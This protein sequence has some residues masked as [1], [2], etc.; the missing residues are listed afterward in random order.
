MRLNL[1]YYQQ[2]FDINR[3][4]MLLLTIGG[5]YFLGIFLSNTFVNIYLWRQSGDYVTIAVYNLAVYL[6]QP[7]AFIL[8]GK[9]A[10]KVDRVIV[11]RLGVIFLSLFFLTVLIIGDQASKYNFLLGSVLGIGYGFYWLA[12]NV[13]TFEITEPETR[14]IFNGFLGVLQ[15][16]GGMIGPLMAGIIIAKMTE[17]MGYTTIFAISFGL[18][19]LAVIS[20]FFINRRQAEGSF[21]FRRILNERNHNRNWRR[22]LSAHVTQGLREGI[23]VFVISIWVY[24]VTGSEFS[25]GVFN[26]VLSGL[27]FVFY[28]IATKFIKPYLRKKSILLGASILYFSIFIIL[29]DISYPLLIVYAI[30]IGMAYPIINVPYNSMTYDVIGK[31]WRAKELRVEYIVVRELFVNIGRVTS[32]LVFLLAV[33]LMPAEDI[34]PWLLVIFG[35]GHLFIYLF[36]K[37]IYLQSSNKQGMI[38]EDQ[39][40]DEK[41][42]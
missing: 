6:F 12:F 10:K 28:F 42:R 4:L 15:S 7:A 37:D 20:S 29:F 23:F 40:T 30:F 38:I 13:L 11:L 24:L 9:F 2:K 14:D 22:I 21:H 19:I 32:I 36:V 34:I 18:F 41:N 31:A 25:L 26:L 39:I 8:A 33:S 27:S 5:L 1:Q 3:D 35:T 17:G 16:F